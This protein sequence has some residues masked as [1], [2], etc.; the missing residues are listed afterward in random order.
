MASFMNE[1]WLKASTPQN[2]K[3]GLQVSGIWS[4]NL[5]IF[6]VWTICHL[7]SRTNPLRYKKLKLHKKQSLGDIQ[8]L[9]QKKEERRKRPA[10]RE[11]VA[12]STPEMKQVKRSLFT[13]SKTIVK[14][15]KTSRQL[16]EDGNDSDMD[17]DIGDLPGSDSDSCEETLDFGSVAE[18]PLGSYYVLCEFAAAKSKFC[19]IGHVLKIE[20]E[21]GDLEVGFFRRSTKIKNKFIKSGQ[22]DIASFPKANVLLVPKFQG[23]TK[24]T[25]EELIFNNDFGRFDVR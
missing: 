19:Y 7:P 18:V 11:M 3:S 10:G 22:D 5:T 24:R 21:D 6:T 13:P 8:R 23:T 14:K 16:F 4:L 17:A 25:K 15:L 2:V 1:A 9:N 20:D 12:A